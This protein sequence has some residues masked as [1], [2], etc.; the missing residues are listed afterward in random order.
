MNH[1]QRVGLAVGPLF[2]RVGL[3]ITFV[4]AGLSKVL[5][6]DMSVHGADAVLLADLGVIL[7]PAPRPSVAPTPAP[8]NIP[9]APNEPKPAGTPEGKPES[10][11]GPPPPS[12]PLPTPGEKAPKPPAEP[13][14]PEPV[15]PSPTKP[16]PAKPEPSTPKTEPKADPKAVP[17]TPPKIS[18]GHAARPESA[19]RDEGANFVR[20]QGAAPRYTAADFVEPV[21]VKRVHYI[22]LLLV[23]AANPGTDANGKPLMALWPTWAAGGRWPVLLAWAAVV[24]ELVGGAFVLLGFLTRFWSLGLV[25]TMFVAAWLTSFGPAF[26]SGNTVWGFI[27]NHPRFQLDAWQVPLW[28]L[29]LSMGALSLFFMG[30]GAWSLDR[31]LFGRGPASGVVPTVS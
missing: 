5:V 7:S 10:K 2:L 6:E 21:K 13:V 24:T 4:W 11:P 1:R 9:P 12:E 31:L 17:K 3:G 29:M 20:T 16:A 28:Q 22:T 30:S 14:K 8:T 26:Q 19:P 23:K 15:K 18:L 25:F 27:P